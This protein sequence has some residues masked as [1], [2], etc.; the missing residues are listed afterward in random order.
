MPAHQ[1]IGNRFA[2]AAIRVLHGTTVTD[3][4]PFRAIRTSLLRELD[5]REMTYGWPTEMTVK[6]VLAR[7]AVVEV[8]VTWSNRLAG[9]SKVGGTVRG[10]LLAAWHIGRVTVALVPRRVRSRVRA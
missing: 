7:A 1:R 6:A 8:P 4:G 2:A 3:L 5:M 10:S 9:R